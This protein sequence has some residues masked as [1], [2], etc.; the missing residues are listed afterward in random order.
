MS[1]FQAIDR[2]A[3]LAAFA[4]ALA[5]VSPT[6]HAQQQKP[7][8]AAMATARE[9]VTITGATTLFNPVIDGV[10]EQAKILFL[11]QNPALA[12]D[13]NEIAADLRTQLKPR[14]SELTNEVTR[15][16]A[17]HFTEPEL[18]QV[19]AF[20]RSPAG[21]KLITEQPKIADASLRFAQDWA[22]KLS[23]EVMGKMR[24]EM[25]KRGHDM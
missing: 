16:Y 21:K 22:N 8:A 9:I 6:A 15:E 4:L 23:D 25:K 18:K 5:L 10:I 3:G 13:L 14:F 20:Y 11:Q 2:A 24:A 12:K 17:L 7:S 1:V 19:L